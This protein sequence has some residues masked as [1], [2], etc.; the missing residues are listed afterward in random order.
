MA[1]AS[2]DQAWKW[3]QARAKRFENEGNQARAARLITQER[4]KAPCSLYHGMLHPLTKMPIAG[5]LWYPGAR[6]QDDPPPY[7]TLFPAAI[8]GWREAWN[9]GDFPFVFIQ[10]PAYHGEGRNELRARGFPL[11]REAQEQALKLPHTGMATIIDIGQANDI[12]PRNKQDVGWRLA[13]WALHQTYNMKNV[14]PSG[15]LFKGH[16]VEGRSIRLTFDNT[17]GGLIVGAIGRGGPMT[18]LPFRV[19][20]SHRQFDN[21]H[22]RWHSGRR[23]RWV[24]RSSRKP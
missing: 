10:L 18:G 6:S 9:Q 4:A 17:G 1:R 7:R 22:Q 5:M 11:V 19:E 15:P 14:V 3:A 13:Q 16:K 21:R 8:R 20:L 12:H 24:F 23:R 2:S